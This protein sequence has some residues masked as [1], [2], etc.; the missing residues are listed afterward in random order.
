M[1]VKFDDKQ[2]ERFREYRN[3]EYGYI[4]MNAFLTI[5]IQKGIETDKKEKKK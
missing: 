1:L 2:A 5:M 3:S 4:A